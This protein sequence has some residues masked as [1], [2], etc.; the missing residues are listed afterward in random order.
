MKHKIMQALRNLTASC[1]DLL[2]QLTEHPSFVP[3]L[4]RKCTKRHLNQKEEDR[5]LQVQAL[6]VVWNLCN[7]P[8]AASKLL[9]LGAYDALAMVVEMPFS[10]AQEIALLALADIAKTDSGRV[11]LLEARLAVSLCGLAKSLPPPAA[12]VLEGIMRVFHALSE[13]E[14]IKK[15]N[16][17][18]ASSQ[19]PTSSR[20]ADK[21]S[22]TNLKVDEHFFRSMGLIDV[23]GHLLR[24]GGEVT[25]LLALG[26]TL[27]PLHL[28]VFLADTS[29]IR[30]PGE[31]LPDPK[32][33]FSNSELSW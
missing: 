24:N 15:M 21:P 32:E 6:G 5:M 19:V 23:I 33:Y 10:E 3:W 13:T 28:F 17:T 1:N 25:K 29:N 16:Q 20:V 31:S 30:D 12:G 22:V 7:S 26:E 18:R 2:I 27:S 8:N 11:R 14:Q 9:M 4:L